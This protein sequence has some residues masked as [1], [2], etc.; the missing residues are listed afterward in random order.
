MVVLKPEKE[1][2]TG[3]HF[4]ETDGQ[5]ELSIL[6]KCGGQPDSADDGGRPNAANEMIWLASSAVNLE[7]RRDEDPA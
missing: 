2:I 1:N 3:V 6:L 5:F 4:G 7:T